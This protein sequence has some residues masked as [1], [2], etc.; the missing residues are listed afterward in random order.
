MRCLLLSAAHW[1]SKTDPPREAEREVQWESE[2]V[3]ERERQNACL[4]HGNQNGIQIETHIE[5]GT[6]AFYERVAAADQ[7]KRELIE[8]C[9]ADIDNKQCEQAEGEPQRG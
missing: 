4:Q 1:Q 6:F 2:L 5:G 9:C 8:I 7:V 3:R